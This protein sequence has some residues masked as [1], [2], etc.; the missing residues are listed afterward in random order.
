LYDPESRLTPA[1]AAKLRGV[2]LSKENKDRMTG[3][4][5]P[6]EKHGRAVRY[7]YATLL[8]WMEERTR[9][10]TSDPGRAA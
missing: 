5:A 10:S 9:R 8:R 4:S 1:Q 2:S 3:D 7:R 6:F